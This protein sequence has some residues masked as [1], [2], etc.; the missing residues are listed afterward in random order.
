M[1]KKRSYGRGRIYPRGSRWWVEYRGKRYPTHSE[2]EADALE[3]L[4][5]LQRQ[6]ARGELT[7]PG[8]YTI[9]EAVREYMEAKT[10]QP[11]TKHAYDSAWTLHLKDFFGDLDVTRLTTDRL[12][13]YRDKRCRE[14]VRQGNNAKKPRKQRKVGETSINR[15]L[16]LLRAALRRLSKRRPRVLPAVP[17]FPMESEKGN[18]RKGFVREPD[19][20]A[21]LL[22]E[23][24]EHL[25]TITI[26]NFYAGGREGEWLGLIWPHVDFEHGTVYFPKTKNHDAREVPIF[27]EMLEP[28]LRL[29][30]IRDA[31]WPEQQHVFLYAGNRLKSIGRAW[32]KACVR[33]GF[34]GLLFHDLRR[35]ASKHMAEHGVPKEVRKG[36]QGHLTDEMDSRY[37]IVDEADF[38]LAREK[39]RHKRPKL[40]RVK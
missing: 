18:V 10:L 6:D 20:L 7:E 21:R 23:L 3:Y 1:A 26:C 32:D 28:L 11:G 37:N 24:P 2:L 5:K 38:D 29:K 36:L 40:R 34:P 33:A 17:Y 9:A 39:M 16:A 30:R 4:A 8:S 14:E 25:K 12:T 35:S 27:D 19:L 13:E 31:A 22:P 15:E